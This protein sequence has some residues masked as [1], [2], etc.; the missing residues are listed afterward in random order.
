[1]KVLITFLTFLLVVNVNAQWTQ[2]NGPTLT[3][4]AFAKSGNTL[5]AASDGNGI[6]ASTNDGLT[7]E[8]INGI[9][10]G[11]VLQD[12]R[13][14]SLFED[15]GKLYAGEYQNGL[16]YSTNKGKSWAKYASPVNNYGINAI[17]RVDT[18]L[19]AGGQYVFR[20]T[21]GGSSWVT[22][23]TGLPSNFG[24]VVA[25][26]ANS[27]TVFAAVN[28]GSGIYRST[29][30]GASWSAANN[31]IN[32]NSICA[33]FA[34]YAETI[35][36][37]LS[38]GSIYRT[39]NNGVQWDSIGTRTYANCI[40]VNAD[41]I[42]VGLNNNYIDRSTDGGITWTRLSGGAQ[43]PKT[44]FLDNGK[45]FV[46]GTAA[47]FAGNGGI[48][49]STNGGASWTRTTTLI[50]NGSINS[51]LAI[52][53][54]LLL[55]ASVSGWDTIIRGVWSS[56][57]KGYT[58]KKNTTVTISGGTPITLS[59]MQL[60]ENK[61]FASGINVSGYGSGVFISSDTGN[62][63]QQS[64][65]GLPTNPSIE[66]IVRYA[67]TIF[68][69]SGKIYR[70]TNFGS[71][72]V[73]WNGNLPSSGSV[74]S[75]LLKGDTLFAARGSDYN[76]YRSV[77]G[78]RNWQTITTN[79][80]TSTGS[81]PQKLYTHN[82]RLYAIAGLGRIYWSEDSGSTWTESTGITFTGNKN[83][84]ELL[85]YD[86]N[87]FVITQS[88]GLY[89]STNNGQT[90]SQMNQG[91]G[92][93][94]PSLSNPLISWGYFYVSSGGK[95]MRRQLSE[96]GIITNVQNEGSSTLPSDFVLNQ[97]YPNPFN[98]STK[99]TWQ[100]PVS[101]YTTLKV[102]DV[103]GREVATLV[104]EY[105]NAG[106]YEVEFN[107]FGLSSGVYLCRLINNSGYSKTIKMLLSK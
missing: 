77:D 76:I 12:K 28:N 82:N 97:N 13:I 96:F 57:D 9:Q 8:S 86:N 80:P 67:D 99:I 16:Y 62:T 17:V 50:L 106:S 70:S 19:I 98:P 14:I 48:F 64:I 53:E 72:W 5:L 107:A 31:G 23:I 54:K 22:A 37:L 69:L 89:I 18:V 61:I 73:L 79:L 1:M 43:N 42:Y 7:W 51:F 58:W 71:S 55:S 92:E 24:Q 4:N 46:G 66:Q 52:G 32:I 21:N 47:Q 93:S 88:E 35:Y 44:I 20:S 75:L 25:M 56:M 78:G 6:H 2:I 84:K 83:A 90:W 100:S 101:G 85:F 41:T 3:I 39:N 34:R 87:I 26:G 40:A 94:F 91:I 38:N 105:L 63:W 103:L 49:L 15:N 29:N 45:V 104:N 11:Q 27:T 81:T 10:P 68:V 36:V 60:I 30:Y 33:G 102:Y 65:S 74:V 95:I 59:K